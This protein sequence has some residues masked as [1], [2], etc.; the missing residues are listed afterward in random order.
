MA[1]RRYYGLLSQVLKSSYKNM[2]KIIISLFVASALLVGA[3]FA[4]A[5]MMQNQNSTTVTTQQAPT[6]TIASVLQDI[7]TSQNITSPTPIDCSKVTDT[8]FEKLG[9]AYMG[10][11]IT[12]AQHTVM[13]NMMGGEGSATVKQAHISMGRAYVGCWAGYNTQMRPMMSMMNGGAS[14]NNSINYNP[15]GGMMGWSS[16]GDGSYG[17]FSIFH[18]ITM[19][20]VW[21][22]L[23]L[24][25][26]FLWKHIKAQK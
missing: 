11:G 6:P 16:V 2:K 20:L 7:Y 19:I 12:E 3:S 22:L 5:S 13:E 8:Q 25:I 21:V 10:N 23:I 14:N 4:G 9:D 18:W 15:R 1:T 17:V 24:G 26:L